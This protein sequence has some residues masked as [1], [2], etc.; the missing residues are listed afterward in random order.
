M[1][2]RSQTTAQYKDNNLYFE[3]KLIYK[4]KS[5]H[6]VHSYCFTDV[7]GGGGGGGWLWHDV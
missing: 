3:C 1:A 2:A 4:L 6:R 7:R 5:S